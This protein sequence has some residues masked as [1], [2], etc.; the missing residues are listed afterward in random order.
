M[1]PINF[2]K[3]NNNLKELWNRNSTSI[4]VRPNGSMKAG[5]IK[6]PCGNVI[7]AISIQESSISEISSFH[8][9]TNSIEFYMFQSQL[10]LRLL[11]FQPQS[12]HNKVS[13]TVKIVKYS[14]G[15]TSGKVTARILPVNY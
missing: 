3:S 6:T 4:R 5:L 15:C 14:S 10:F 8:N 7:N 2:P 12:S 11:F 1:K 9:H 13:P